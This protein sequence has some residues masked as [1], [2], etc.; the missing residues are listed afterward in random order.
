MSFAPIIPMD[1]PPAKTQIH[2]EYCRLTTVCAANNVCD[3]V[4][5]AAI[6]KN[7]LLVTILL[8]SVHRQITVDET[9]QFLFDQCDIIVKP[10]KILHLM[11]VVFARTR[12]ACTSVR[13]VQTVY[14]ILW[15]SL[16]TYNH[17]CMPT[18]PRYMGFVGPAL[19]DLLRVVCLIAFPP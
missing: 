18:I 10:V 2:M 14:H 5:T 7:C 15:S 13:T 4:W 3:R 11:G 16:T 19:S 6:S 12:Y 17:T 8:S 9:A 1:R